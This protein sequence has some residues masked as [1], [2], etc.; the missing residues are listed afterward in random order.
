MG[1]SYFDT[2]LI[3]VV[4]IYLIKAPFTKV[5]ESF[6]IQAIHDILNYG[7]FDLSKYDHFKFPG[8]VP[9]TFIGS[10]II[11]ALTKPFVY[12]SALIS[13]SKQ[14]PTQFES[15]LLSRCMIGLTNALSLIFLKNCAQ[16][17]FDITAK[18]RED[19]ET[20]RKELGTAVKSRAPEINLNTVGT[21][22]LLFAMTGFHLM[23]YGSRPLPNF[24]MTLPLTN[25]AIGWTLLGSYQWAIF[26][27]AFTS[28]I[29]RLE[30]AALGS[31]IALLSVFYKRLSLTKAIKFGL[32]GFAIGMGITLTIDSYFWQ[33]WCMPEVDAFIFNVLQGNAS[34]WG[35]ES[36]FAYFSHY[37]RMLFI[38]PTILALNLLGFKVAPTNLKIVTLA[39]YFHIAVLSLQPHKEWRF[40]VYAIPPII[41]LGSTAAAYLW[42]NVKV[43]GIRH[44]LLVV[45]IPLS[46]LLSLIFSVGFL[47]VSSMNYPGGEALTKFNQMIINNNITNVTVHL[48]IPVCMTGVTL[49]GELNHDVYGVQYD[50]TEN[51]AKLEEAWPTFDYLITSAPS[52]SSL[53]FDDSPSDH[54]KLVQTSDVFIGVNTSV[55]NDIWFKEDK[56]L[57]V[58]LKDGFT[59]KNSLTDQVLG[60]F[61]DILI[62]ENVFFTYQRLP[63]SDDL[64]ERN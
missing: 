43:D 2:A 62:R 13:G 57:F 53:P 34:K 14:A 16:N 19:D 17:S 58:V 42:E 21:W 61:D 56:N 10:L 60:L 46:P 1:W 18:E 32:M 33:K 4:S 29:F 23:F 15:Q 36:P 54:W 49:F 31:G 6:T 9:R 63:S 28:A 25:I 12:V 30:V 20:R 24:V 37:L 47:Y 27:L 35:V 8:A 50:R 5:E 40:I 51:P 41:L 52:A 11:S 26:L 55:I 22:F 39:S 59:S 64:Q 45:L 44:F 7:V 48:D 38:P 3:V